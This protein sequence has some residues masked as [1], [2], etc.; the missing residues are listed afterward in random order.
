MRCALPRGFLLVPLTVAGLFTPRLAAA[1]DRPPNVVIVF[2]DDLG[3]GD[4]GC[5]GA[6]GYSTPNLDRLAR[7]GVRFTDFYAAQP[8]CSASRVALLTGCY[9]NR[10]GI[11]GALNP[12]SKHGISDAE[13]TLGQLLKQRGYATAVFGKWHLGHHPKFL[14]PR[15]GF[16]EYFGLPYS[17]DM[18]PRHPTAQFPGLPLID[19]DQTVALN[20]DQTQLTTWYTR[21]AMR[22]IARNKDR[23]FLLYVA[24]AMPHV[25]LHVSDKFKGKSARGLF[26]DVI[27]EIDWSVGQILGALKGHGLDDRTLVI[28][29]SDNGPWLSYGDHAGSA[30]PLREGKMTTWDGGQREPCLMRWPGRIPAGAVCRE[31]AMTIDLFPTLARL[32]GAPLPKHE[33]DGLDIWPLMAAQP[34]AKGPHEALYFYWNH[35]LQGVRSGRWKLHFPHTYITLGGQPGGK[36]GKPA[37][38]VKGKTELALYDLNNDVGETINV[39][40]EHPDVVARLKALADKAREDL[41]D[42]ATK[43][44]GKGVRPAGSI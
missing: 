3:Y 22:F 20:H 21:R 31:P 11:L 30:G 37:K 10:L 40:A 44:Q 34:G 16:D 29:T 18:W 41:G 26:G 39:A 24:H 36:G 27:M 28:F 7:E 38:Y 43:Q 19:G 15:H 35:E 13:M 1:A 17:N 32:A 14:P 2:A 9:P 4:L 33:I 8:V 5:Y 42:S 23:P 25:P 12:R 6:R